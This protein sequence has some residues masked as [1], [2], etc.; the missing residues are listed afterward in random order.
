MPSG[1]FSHRTLPSLRRHLAADFDGPRAEPHHAVVERRDLD[2]IVIP[3]PDV[4]EITVRHETEKLLG[5]ACHVDASL[6]DHTI[7]H[8][9]NPPVALPQLIGVERSF[10]GGVPR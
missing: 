1:D 5:G 3:A 4:L 9:T 10:R 2:E 8:R 6:D 7:E